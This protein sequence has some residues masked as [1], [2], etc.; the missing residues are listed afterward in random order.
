MVEV[1]VCHAGPVQEGERDEGQGR[2]E[3]EVMSVDNLT[4][5]DHKENRA[6]NRITQ[7]WQVQISGNFRT[8]RD[9]AL[10]DSDVWR[11]DVSLDET[12]NGTIV[13]KA[14]LGQSARIALQ[15]F[16]IENEANAI[17]RPNGRYL[18]GSV[19]GAK[20]SRFEVSERRWQRTPDLELS[21]VDEANSDGDA[22]RVV[23]LFN[24][25]FWKNKNDKNID[26][27]SQN[28]NV[29]ALQLETG[30]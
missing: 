24:F 23:F 6:Q 16:S 1:R 28:S 7:I 17:V 15:N 2:R 14:E 25:F 30:K 20:V 5:P 26:I 22:I 19:T 21:F 10:T 12:V 13:L 29:V 18:A 4:P 8:S 11:D 27:T 3:G 9:A